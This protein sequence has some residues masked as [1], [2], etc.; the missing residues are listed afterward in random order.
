MSSFTSQPRELVK[1]SRPHNVALSRV[2]LRQ[3][4]RRFLITVV[5]ALFALSLPYAIAALGTPPGGEYSGLL[6]T[7]SDGYVYLSQI[8]HS[9]GGD[10]LFNDWFTYRRVSPLPVYWVYTAAGH[11]LPLTATPLAVGLAFHVSRL[12]L[13]AAFMYQLWRLYTEVVP[14]AVARRVGLVFALFAGGLG[15]WAQLLHV[16]ISGQQAF[17]LSEFESSTFISLLYAPHFVV[18]LIAI[19][20]FLRAFLRVVQGSPR[21]WSATVVAGIAGAVL[22]SI[23]PEKGILLALTIAFCLTWARL[24]GQLSA[25]QVEQS[26]LV[27]A[28][29]ASYAVALLLILFRDP[30]GLVWATE[31]TREVARNPI[32]YYLLGYGLPGLFAL[33]GLPGVIRRRRYVSHAELL[34]WS[35]VAANI[36]ILAIPVTKLIHRAEGL[37]L[38]LCA[39][40]AR[41]LILQ[42]LP[43]LWRSGWFEAVSRVHPLGYSRRRLRELTINLPVI[44]STT[45]V[46]ALALVVPR[47]ALSSEP[48][49]FLNRDDLTAIAYVRDQISASDVV[50]GLPE[51]EDYLAA[52]GGVHV[53][54]GAFSATPDSNNEQR[55]MAVFFTRTDLDLTYLRDRSVKWL[56]FGPREAATA[57]FD[58]DRAPRLVKRFQGGS[59]RIYQVSP[60]TG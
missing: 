54:L 43:R 59:T 35:M 16:S 9:H 11:L 37:H 34:L 22:V 17:D 55:Q 1:P 58:P 24:R 12:C 25:R 39:L 42:L 21:S 33:A 10:W 38:V 6:L 3:T 50:I 47:T 7:P 48:E 23:H 15:V 49:I 36:V 60:A 20:V 19:V 28:L 41:Y 13:A 57:K 2:R 46:L 52:Y 53:V 26:A 29:A 32:A 40:A 14:N 56:Y 4:H 31:G 51:T 30:V 5:L 45:S 44:L 8:Y 27:L 18:A